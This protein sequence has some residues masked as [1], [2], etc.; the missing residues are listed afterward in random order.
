MTLD[1]LEYLKKEWIDEADNTNEFCERSLIVSALQAVEE[2][3]SK[4]AARRLRQIMP[5]GGSRFVDPPDFV[6]EE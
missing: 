4:E 5:F 3:N 2:G 1:E 6:E